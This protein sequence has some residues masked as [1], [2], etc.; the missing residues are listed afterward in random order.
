MALS[1]AQSQQQAIGLGERVLLC[2]IEL[3]KQYDTSAEFFELATSAGVQVIKQCFIKRQYPEAQYFIG[4]GKVDH[5]ASLVALRHIEVVLFSVNLSPSQQRN[6]ELSIKCRVMDRTSLILDIFALRAHSYEGKL[7]V[8][9]AQLKHLSTRLV[10]TWTHLERQKGGLGLRGPGETQLETD[11]RLIGMRINYLKK[12]LVKVNKQRQLGRQA[13]AKNEVPVV[14]LVGYTNAGKSSLFNTLTKA[15]VYTDNKLFATL[16]TTLRKI[17]LPALGTTIVADTVGFIQDLP[18]DLIAAFKSTLNEIKQADVLLHIVDASDE[19]KLDKIDKVNKILTAINLNN[20]AS[21]TVM[22]KIDKLV[23]PVTVKPSADIVWI[24]AKTTEGLD[25]LS[26]VL[27]K[28]LSGLM[29]SAH[30]LLKPK[31]AKY[32]NQIYK[33]G[34][35][36]AEKTDQYGNWI[37][38]ILVTNHYLTR[39][40]RNK[41]IEL[42]QAT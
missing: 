37:L 31:A 3:P 38:E 14:A 5:I 23:Y 26:N 32:R 7:Q 41:N 11:R 16:D 9:L 13:R 4:K 27:T 33:V 24:S 18:P 30:I 15:N 17:T 6:L 12:R 40:L 42:W 35:I 29:Q 8:E 36:K 19:N 2:H 10:R 28:K 1:F 21:I 22:N 20:I 34:F 39:L 25:I